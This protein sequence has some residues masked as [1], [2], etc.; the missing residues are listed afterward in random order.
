MKK[1]VTLILSAVMLF[2]AVFAVPVSAEAATGR[3]KVLKVVSVSTN[4]VKLKW[5]KVKGA[6]TYKVY[7]STNKKK[8][9][10]LAKKVNKKTALVKNLKDNKTYYF[11]VKAVKNGKTGKASPVKSATTKKAWGKI[12]GVSTSTY[13]VSEANSWN[14]DEEGGGF[15]C[16]T[17][18]FN[19][20]RDATAYQVAYYW[21]E[22]SSNVKYKTIKTNAFYYGTQDVNPIFMI[23][24]V[25]TTGGKTKYGPWK[26][27]VV[28]DG[29]YDGL[30]YYDEFQNIIESYYEAIW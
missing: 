22:D 7:Y 15:A 27:V 29:N 28:K 23:R 2:T 13:N 19:K 9:Y 8:G 30:L 12:T 6:K 4:S 16:I 10:K 17:F 11:K 26:K 20:V 18:D 21:A 5:K 1:L 25:K 24:A 14:P 3:V